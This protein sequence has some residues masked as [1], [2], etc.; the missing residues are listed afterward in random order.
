MTLPLF[1]VST[2]DSVGV[3]GVF[4]GSDNWYILL[5]SCSLTIGTYCCCRAASQ[6]VHTAVVVQPYNRYILLLSCILT[7][8]TYCCCRASLQSVHTAVVVQP[9]NRY[10]LL[11][12]CSLTKYSKTAFAI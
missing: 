1:V 11:L 9:H 3:L 5:L 2:A 4:S 6:S 10:I 8:G 7:I 12:S